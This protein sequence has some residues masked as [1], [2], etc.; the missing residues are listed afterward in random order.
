MDANDRDSPQ[1]AELARKD[2]EWAARSEAS[3]HDAALSKHTAAGAGS[4][5]ST[6]GSGQSSGPH[7]YTTPKNLRTSTGPRFSGRGVLAVFGILGVLLTVGIMAFLAVKVLDGVSNPNGAEG[8]DSDANHTP[9]TPV[10][11]GV[12]AAPVAPGVPGGAGI[13]PASPTDAARGAA[14][15]AERAAVESAAATFELVH[16]NRPNSVDELV[17][18]GY[19]T[20]GDDGFSHELSDG[21]VVPT[22]D[23]APG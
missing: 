15:E 8:D 11:P 16:G 13:D 2:R 12:P 1:D 4:A 20:P 5:G 6:R 19:L 3:L 22:G 10:V 21:T 18:G 9:E 14:C 17:S 23:C 7:A